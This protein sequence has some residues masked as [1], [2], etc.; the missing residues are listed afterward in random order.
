MKKYIYLLIVLLFVTVFPAGARNG[1]TIFTL[2]AD[3]VKLL[4]QEAFKNN[5][6][7][8]MKALE[9]LALEQDTSASLVVE[10]LNSK[11]KTVRHELAEFFKVPAGNPAD[12]E[13]YLKNLID[14]AVNES[15][16]ILKSRLENFGISGATI[17]RTGSLTIT[18]EIKSP[19][20]M[21]QVKQLISTTG[22]L[23]FHLVKDAGISKSLQES[24]DSMLEKSNPEN[25]TKQF[26]GLINYG[27]ASGLNWLPVNVNSIADAEKILNSGESLKILQE[28]NYAW[29]EKTIETMTDKYRILYFLNTE[30]AL[31]EDDISDA[32]YSTDPQSGSF[33]THITLNESGATSW[34][35]FTEESI[36]KE[37]AI[38][39]DGYVFWAPKIMT[40]ITGGKI[41]VSG[42]AGLE[43]ART[44]SVLIKNGALHI[45]LGIIS[46]Q[47]K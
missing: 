22:R 1:I 13:D 23:S 41:M 20:D 6:A 42:L 27:L 16:R 10:S 37:C 21:K 38:V 14:D 34:E 36:G 8:L 12:V 18:V 32:A 47:T 40:K 46:E 43:E 30:S 2:K 45:P 9:E 19:A 4:K 17:N 3:A 11:L 44:L 39:F 5:D 25:G 29:S 7:V 33:F 24:I 31:T 26:T 28:I 35:K 15:V